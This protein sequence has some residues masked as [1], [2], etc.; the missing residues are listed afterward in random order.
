MLNSLRTRHTSFTKSQERK[1]PVL[2]WQRKVL[3]LHNQLT[4]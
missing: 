1:S 2:N 4:A 3:R